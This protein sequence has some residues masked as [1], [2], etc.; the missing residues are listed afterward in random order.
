MNVLFILSDALRSSNL[1]CYGYRKNTS[2]SIDRLATH[3]EFNKLYK[4]GQIKP[5]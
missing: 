3:K 5:F 2:S 4:F 1:G